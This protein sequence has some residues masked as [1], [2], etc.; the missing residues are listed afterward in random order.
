[1]KVTL[2]ACLFGALVARHASVTPSR[3]LDI[4]TGT[5]VLALMMAQQFVPNA[6]QLQIDAVELDQYAAQQA[7]ENA[8]RSVF[9]QQVRVIASSIESLPLERC[10][11]LIIT[12]PPFFSDSLTGPDAARNQARHNQELSFAQLS[13]EIAKRLTADGEAWVLLPVDEMQRFITAA[14]EVA[15]SPT[16]HWLVRS[17]PS[18]PAY[19]SVMCFR[20]QNQPHAH[21]ED[22]LLVTEEI[23]VREG[24][25]RTNGQPANPCYSPAFTELLKPFYLKL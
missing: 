13:A 9:R 6:P 18:S 15:L 20:H 23:A 2:D 21:T 12:N 7:S 24:S 4:G 25:S 22:T 3:I 10:Y 5:G 1:M 19:R 8:A 17:Q 11:D 14:N 16:V